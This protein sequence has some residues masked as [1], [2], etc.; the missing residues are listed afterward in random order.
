M[1]NLKV[2]RESL[3]KSVYNPV[4]VEL[5]NQ[6]YRAV[7]N[8]I[9]SN[10]EAL[11]IGKTVENTISRVLVKKDV[12]DSTSLNRVNDIINEHPGLFKV[13]GELVQDL[14]IHL[15][16]IDGYT[17]SLNTTSKLD[18][19]DNGWFKKLQLE[20]SVIAN[21]QEWLNNGATFKSAALQSL[22][23]YSNIVNRVSTFYN[24]D[25]AYE[26]FIK[27]SKISEYSA[28][29]TFL[30]LEHRLLCILGVK[31][32]IS[33]GFAYAALNGFPLFL[34]DV[35]ESIYIKLQ[36]KQK[37]M[38]E[39]FYLRVRMPLLFSGVVGTLGLGWYQF[40]AISV[41]KATTDALS[42]FLYGGNYYSGFV[43]NIKRV[44]FSAGN[45]VGSSSGSFATG[46]LTGNKLISGLFDWASNAG[47]EVIKKIKD[48]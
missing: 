25:Y 16:T 28:V 23:E 40:A 3:S 21:F 15:M 47:Q 18:I 46:L 2:I 31:C 4:D 39:R 42:P 10:R 9:L 14:K 5:H 24:E 11:N 32:F 36:N 8:E 22:P 20:I 26:V 37:Y 48:K 13:K 34:K 33:S 30:L 17:S 41:P 7:M 12:D 1:I 27:L 43:D 6:K 45:L 35:S 19:L 44:M 29:S 38:L